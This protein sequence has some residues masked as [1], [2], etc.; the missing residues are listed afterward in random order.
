MDRLTLSGMPVFDTLQPRGEERTYNNPMMDCSSM[1][2]Y[3]DVMSA[4]DQLRDGNR[5]KTV[6]F[7][8]GDD[9]RSLDL[10][11]SES[12]DDRITNPHNHPQPNMLDMQF[13]TLSDDEQSNGEMLELGFPPESDVGDVLDLGFDI[14]VSDPAGHT[15]GVLEMGFNMNHVDELLDLR[16]NITPDENPLEMGFNMDLVHESPL[17]MG[18]DVDPAHVDPDRSFA[19][20]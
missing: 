5:L 9:H 19:V 17:E 7:Q 18:F 20:I 11:F 1:D 4:H 6:H 12:D 14:D 10:G 13:P 16:N 15:D 8:T 3:L 2:E